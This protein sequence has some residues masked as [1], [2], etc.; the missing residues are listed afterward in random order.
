MSS[1]FGEILERVREVGNHGQDMVKALQFNQDNNDDPTLDWDAMG[2]DA[3][4]IQPWVDTSDWRTVEG[5]G[6]YFYF[7][8]KGFRVRYFR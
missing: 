4:R 2:D 8:P 3:N 7:L 6:K 1:S 5:R